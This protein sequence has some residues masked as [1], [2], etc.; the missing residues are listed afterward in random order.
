MVEWPHAG[1]VKVHAGVVVDDE[2][3]GPLL[4]HEDVVRLVVMYEDWEEV[5]DPGKCWWLP[6]LM[7]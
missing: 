5:V 6:P 1:V 4:L 3:N 2:E 7:M